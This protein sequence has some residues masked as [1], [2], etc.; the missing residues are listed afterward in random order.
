MTERKQHAINLG[1]VRLSRI[2][3][4]RKACRGP[5]FDAGWH[6]SRTDVNR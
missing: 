5:P 2:K 3:R 6:T 1:P 4:I